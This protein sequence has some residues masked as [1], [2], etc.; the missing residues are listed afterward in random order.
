MSD[1]QQAGLIANDHVGSGPDYQQYKGPEATPAPYGAP[2]NQDRQIGFRDITNAI[3][4]LGTLIC[5]LISYGITVALGAVLPPATTIKH[6]S[7]IHMH[8]HTLTGLRGCR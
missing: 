2:Q 7:A 1:S 4:D 6:N 8:N 5:L 3:V